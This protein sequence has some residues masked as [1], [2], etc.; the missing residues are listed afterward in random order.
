MCWQGEVVGQA[1]HARAGK[2]RGICRID[3][4]IAPHIMTRL[5]PRYSATVEYEGKTAIFQASVLEKSASTARYDVEPI[6]SCLGA[7]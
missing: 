7:H 4:T 5:L 1:L 3:P 6:T 2:A